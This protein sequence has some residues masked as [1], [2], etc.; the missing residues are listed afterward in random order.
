MTRK[1]VYAT[2]MMAL[3]A[4]TIMTVVS[5]ATP[6][7]LTYSVSTPMGK[8]FKQNIGLHKS[9]NSLDTPTCQPFPRPD[10]CQDQQRYF[11]S[12]WR[13]IGFMAALAA[14]LSFATMTCFVVVMYGGK[15]KRET[16]WP[17]VTSMLGL[18]SLV[19]LITIS[20]VAYILNHDEQFHHV[21]DWTLGSSWCLATVGASLTFLAAVG[22]GSSAYLLPPEGGYESLD[23]GPDT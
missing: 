7:W 17:F 19:E 14:I 23:D 21:S 15:L 8:T 9:C 13:S 6:A 18:V 16:G 5:I 12:M 22:M 3:L 11:C 2:A 20:M 1:S 4:S 10:L